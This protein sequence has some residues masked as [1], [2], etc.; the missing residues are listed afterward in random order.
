[1]GVADHDVFE[2]VDLYEEKDM[3]IVVYCLYA[4]GRTIQVRTVDLNTNTEFMYLLTNY[5]IDTADCTGVQGPET[6]T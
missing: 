2:T 3:S 5:L 4:L 6:W 1:M